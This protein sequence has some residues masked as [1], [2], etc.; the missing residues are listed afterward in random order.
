MLSEQWDKAEFD[1]T[2]K[3]PLHQQLREMIRSRILSGQIGTGDLLPPEIELAQ[4]YGVSRTTIRRAL[5]DLTQEG[6]LYRVPGQGTRVQRKRSSAL[7][8][9]AL[10]CPFMHWYMLDVIDGIE[11]VVKSQGL[12]LVVRN[13]G[14]NAEVEAQQ[15]NE[16]LEMSVAGI[17]LW[18]KTPEFDSSPSSA[19]SR[20]QDG[21]VPMVVIDQYATKVDTVNTDNFGG[22]YVMGNH[23][24]NVG[25]NRIGFV[26]D[27]QHLPS[28]VQYRWDGLQESLRNHDL[29]INPHLLFQK[30]GDKEAFADWFAQE[31]PDALFCAN[32]F[33]ALEAVSL[34]THMNVRIPEDVAVVGYDDLPLAASVHPPLTTIKQDF[35]A[36]GQSAGRLLVR[37]VAEPGLP[38]RHIVL[39][40]QLQV[41]QSCGVMLSRLASAD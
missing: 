2:G 35:R 29:P 24:L 16:L 3:A 25:H 38:P 18:P 41:R 36:V 33:L 7:K 34:L 10:I 13:S 5:L 6:L 21:S 39:P 11:S 9:V 26:T 4:V 17:V 22:A 23:L 37:K 12:E 31:Q 20:L 32:D 28:T 8:A 15:I 27:H 19:V 1:N 14:K 30:W 40:V